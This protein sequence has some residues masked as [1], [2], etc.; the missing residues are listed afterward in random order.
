MGPATR[1]ETRPPSVR[2]FYQDPDY[3][4]LG[5]ILLLAA[6]LRLWGLNAPLWF[7]EIMTLDSH[8]RLPW[9]DMMQTYSMNH[10]YLFSL[11]S[12][13]FVSLFGEAAWTLRL[14]AMLF[15]IGS[16]AALW[17]LARDLT[18]RWTAHITALL[19]ALSFHHIWFSQ[20]ARGY[21]EL[22]FWSTLGMI[23]FL[24]GLRQPSWKTW[25]GYALCL[26]LAVA[27]HLTGAF[28]FVAQGLIWLTLALRRLPKDGLRAPFIVWPAAG[29]LL[30][31]LLILLFYLPVLPSLLETMAG[32]R[33]TG[34]VD[35]MREYSNPFWSVIEG[36]RTAIGDL[37]P[38]IGVILLAV[39]TLA[40][41][42]VYA[43]REKG[44]VYS[45]TIGLHIVVTIALLMALGMR[46]WPRFFFV[47]IG[48]LMLLIVLGV[49]MSTELFASRVKL[50]PA[51]TLYA[52]GIAGMLLVS[53]G[54]TARNYVA[55][56][57]NLI[58]AYDL[59]ETDRAAGNRVYAV[60]VGSEA[61]NGYFE[62]GWDEILSPEDYQAALAVP[63]P[64]TL[65]IAFPARSFRTVPE[66][67]THIDDGTLEMIEAFPG[68]LGDGVVVV[69]RRN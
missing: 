27:T 49:R 55:P 30:G 39:F 40:G 11:Q 63:G 45:L 28:F 65:V 53:T 3:Q 50:V 14:P 8:V 34:N 23:F 52:L 9:G 51:R 64:L 7:D 25:L 22:A 62:A 57:Q 5:G 29:Y 66:M 47:D 10:H 37:G 69:L 19:I 24:Q 38:L 18:D 21:T 43:L 2:R 58:G 15:G 6:V 61:F 1:S 56:K 67:D 32:I 42:G 16:I 33:E 54:L 35:V 41:L 17:W 68:T 31:G 4:I 36:V 26:W 59:A 46:V 12:K 48:F 20:N 44:S 60:G 13:L